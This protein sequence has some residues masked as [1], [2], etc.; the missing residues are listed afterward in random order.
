[1]FGRRNRK[2]SEEYV[3]T[4]IDQTMEYYT[5]LSN[6]PAVTSYSAD[7]ISVL[8]HLKKELGFPKAISEWER[9]RG[10]KQIR[11]KEG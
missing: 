5:E 6:N 3:L 7:P 9:E 8:E 2:L 11:D 4:K 1:M 10:L